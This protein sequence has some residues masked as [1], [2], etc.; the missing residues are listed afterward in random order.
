M[1][2]LFKHLYIPIPIVSALTF[3]LIFTETNKKKGKVKSQCRVCSN[4]T[5]ALISFSHS[6]IL[7]IR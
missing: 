1:K 5:L 4:A 6:F 7:F 3:T 2:S